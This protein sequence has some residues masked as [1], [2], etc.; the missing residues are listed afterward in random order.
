MTVWLTPSHVYIGP[1]WAA[2]GS[3][4]HIFAIPSEFGLMTFL[5][6]KIF[7]FLNYILLL[8]KIMIEFTI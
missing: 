7:F 3:L 2:E 5:H 1:T 4:H 8:I 6:S